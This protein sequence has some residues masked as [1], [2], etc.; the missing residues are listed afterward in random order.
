ML[1]DI[2][3]IQALRSRNCYVKFTSVN[4]RDKCLNSLNGNHLSVF[5]LSFPFFFLREPNIIQS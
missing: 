3:A 5:P 4:A 2:E 1:G